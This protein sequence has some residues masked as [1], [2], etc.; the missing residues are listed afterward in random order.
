MF[1]TFKAH[2]VSNTILIFKLSNWCSSYF[3][4]FVFQSFSQWHHIERWEVSGRSTEREQRPQDILVGRSLRAQ[5]F[6]LVL[7]VFHPA[8][9]YMSVLLQVS[10]EWDEWWC[11]TTLGWVSPGQHR[12]KPPLVRQTHTCVYWH[13]VTN[14]RELSGHPAQ[15]LV[16]RNSPAF[17][18]KVNQQP[19]HCGRDQMSGWGPH[20]QHSTQR[21]MVRITVIHSDWHKVCFSLQFFETVWLEVW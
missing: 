19:V 7:T 18:L 9:M 16:V 15:R 5:G 10:A 6:L 11:S 17:C 2:K 20:S 12:L 21:D 1:N 14:G 13:N 4:V 8:Y 3:S